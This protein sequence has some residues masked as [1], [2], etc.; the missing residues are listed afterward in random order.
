M[1]YTLIDGRAGKPVEGRKR[2]R[3]ERLSMTLS[4]DG[5]RQR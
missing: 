4:A 1:V 5:K 3:I 2:G